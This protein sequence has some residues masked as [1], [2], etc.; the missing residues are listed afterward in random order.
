MARLK[1]SNVSIAALREEID[2]RLSKLESLIS[3][4]DALDIEIQ[5]LKGSEAPAA[6]PAQSPKVAPE[7]KR[8]KVQRAGKP[9]AQYVKEAL[10]AA[11]EGLSVKEIEAKILAAG[12]P[13]KAATIYNPIMKVL[14]KGF[15]KVERG[16]YAVGAAVKAGK[17]AAEAAMAPTPVAKKAARKTRKAVPAA[18]SKTAAVATTKPKPKGKTFSQTAEQFVMDLARDKGA[19]SAEINKAWKKAGRK[20]RADNTLNKMFKAGKVKRAPLKGQ[21]GSTYTLA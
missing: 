15:H 8:A 20:G 1:L 14:G 3:K 9:L 13:T 19:T 10:A 2:R 16:V 21:K 6:T 7:G 18:P 4:R 17:K 11:S 12:Y 5:E